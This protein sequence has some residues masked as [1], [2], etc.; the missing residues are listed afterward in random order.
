MYLK[1]QEIINKITHFFKQHT[2]IIESY[3]IIH[4]YQQNII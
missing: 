3:A 1:T 4:I 2:N